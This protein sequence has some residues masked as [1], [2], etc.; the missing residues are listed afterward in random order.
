MKKVFLTLVLAGTAA[1][2]QAQIQIG[3]KVGVNVATMNLGEREN[4][5]ED[6]IGYAAGLNVGVA[7]NIRFTKMLS[8][9]PEIS[10]SQKGYKY[11]LGTSTM[12]GTEEETFKTNYI[13][14]PLLLRGT[15]GSVV[16]AYVNAGPTLSYWLSGRY[17]GKGNYTE[18]EVT[19]P[20]AYDLEVKFVKEYDQIETEDFVEVSKEHANRFEVGASFGGGVMLPVAGKNFLVDARYTL[21]WKDIYNEMDANEKERNKFLTLSVIYLLGN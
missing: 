12:N 18:N 7:S 6:G 5:V 14:M 1:L 8:F 20:F 3:P 13:D 17:E 21:V 4:K 9:A 19:Q 2:A 15:F 16:K 10:F 11:D